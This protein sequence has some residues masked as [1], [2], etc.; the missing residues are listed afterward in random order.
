[1]TT[2]YVDF[3]N[4][5]DANNG[6]GPDASAGT[7]KPWKTITK[8]LGAAGMA[9][10][11]TAYLAPGSFRETVTVAMT[12]ATVETK[13]LGDPAN[14]QGFKTSGGALVLPGDVIL[15]AYT[16]DDNTLPAAATTLNLNTRDFLTFQDITIM[17]GDAAPS[18]VTAAA[19]STDVKFVRCT[20]IAGRNGSNISMIGA[21]DTA[22]NWTIDSCHFLTFQ[23]APNLLFTLP[24]SA[25]ADY[26][27][28]V[29]IKNS[30]VM[31]PPGATGISITAS[32]AGAFKAGGV[33]VYNSSI[34]LCA[35]AMVT[36]SA[37]I[38]TTIP[39]HIYNSI[40]YGL[41]TTAVLSATTS[42]QI[43]E[44]FNWIVGTIPRSNVS[45]GGSSVA[46]NANGAISKAPLVELGQAALYG[47]QQRPFFSPMTGSKLLGF[48]AQAGGPSTDMIGIQRPAGGASASSA[49]GPYERGNSFGRETGTV[50]TGSNAISITGPGCQDFAVPVDAVS[51]TITSYVRWDATYAG[52][53]PKMQVLNGEECGVTAATAT[54]VGSSGAWEQLSLNFTPTTKGIVTIRL[55]SSDTNGGGKMFADDF[56]IA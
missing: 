36:G 7:N 10:G 16:T 11:D 45:V 32:G 38:A 55:L 43:V 24:T 49:V 14:A 44:D 52:T 6:L 40:A 33:D 17:G 27:V 29:M 41:Q 21:A 4:G 50:R 9:S 3:V 19:I 12:S 18:G 39:C 53:K 20:F 47:R 22:S 28:A 46:A 15:T 26:N 2:Y 30:V 48:G 1:M 25:A 8:L 31:G 54:A 34:L 13:V 37:N 35:Q 42:G 56:A 23:S 5:L 51:T